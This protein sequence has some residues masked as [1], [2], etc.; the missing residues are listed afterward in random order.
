LEWVKKHLGQPAYKR[1]I[2]T[3]HKNLNFGHYLVDDRHKR[4]VENFRGEWIEFGSEQFPDWDSVV[5]Y[6]REKAV[7]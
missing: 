7:A 4:G 6:L 2:L 5:I 1:L 3:H